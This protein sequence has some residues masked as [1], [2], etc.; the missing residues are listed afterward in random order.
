MSQPILTLADASLHLSGNHPTR[1]IDPAE[2]ADTPA[3][4]VG[5]QCGFE[6]YSVAVY[7]DG[8]NESDAMEAA[9]EVHPERGDAD[10]C[11]RIR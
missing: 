7:G 10:Y 5:W 8:L 2:Y 3:F 9:Q 4:V 11:T 6:I 1:P